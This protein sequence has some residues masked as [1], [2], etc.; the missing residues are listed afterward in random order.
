MTESDSQTKY[1]AASQRGI[2]APY[3]RGQAT[4]LSLDAFPHVSRQAPVKVAGKTSRR[5]ADGLAPRRQH[6][7]AQAGEG[8]L[9]ID[10]ERRELE[11]ADGRARMAEAKATVRELRREHA[12][13]ERRLGRRA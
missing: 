9:T 11:L 1:L 3:A 6:G 4:Q 12:R 8:L 2:S 13:L 7:A 5:R 10:P